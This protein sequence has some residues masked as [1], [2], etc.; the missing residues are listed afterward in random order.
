MLRFLREAGVDRE[1]PIFCIGHD[2]GAAYAWNLAP[3]LGS[4]LKGLVILN[5]MS[6]VQM[7]KRWKL[8]QQWL[9]SW[10]IYFLQIPRLPEA[11][12]RIAPKPLHQF[13]YRFGGLSQPPVTDRST[14]LR[15]IVKPIQQYREFLKG[16]E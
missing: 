6:P 7:A 8:P 10:Y 12:T 15:Q 3:F 13:A 16:W 14:S 11:L 4:R 1:R 5:G 2:L 9:K